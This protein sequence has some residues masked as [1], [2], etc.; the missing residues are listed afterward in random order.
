MADFIVVAIVAVCLA[1]SIAHIIRNKKKGGSSCGCGCSG[2]SGSSCCG[3]KGVNP[4][5]F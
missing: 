1:A 2:C 5:D 4:T 3:K